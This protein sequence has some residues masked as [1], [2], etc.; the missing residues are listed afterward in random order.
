MGLWIFSLSLDRALVCFL[1]RT[2]GLSSLR[3]GVRFFV[4][5]NCSRVFDFLYV[6][7]ANRA[8]RFSFRDLEFSGLTLPCQFLVPNFNFLCLTSGGRFFISDLILPAQ[9][10]RVSHS[11]SRS[12]SH[13][14]S[15]SHP[16]C[17]T[18]PFTTTAVC[19]HGSAYDGLTG[20]S[21]AC[22][23]YIQIVVP[24]PIPIPVPMPA[25]PVSGYPVVIATRI[26]R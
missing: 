22:Q 19:L 3:V 9:S 25:H 11:N 1:G 24:I 23:R 7:Y 6:T 2:C 21:R 26:V 5:Q 4:A 10:R 15:L 13:F 17:A 8:L 20:D 12:H 16:A 18:R 14:L